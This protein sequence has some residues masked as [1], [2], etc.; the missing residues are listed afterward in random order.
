MLAASSEFFYQ[1]FIQDES[2]SVEFDVD[3]FESLVVACYSGQIQVNKTNAVRLL[4]AATFYE[5]KSVV[6]VCCDF[7]SRKMDETNCLDVYN[8]T[9]RLGLISLTNRAFEMANERFMALA[10]TNRF[11]DISLEVLT[12]LLASSNL[13]VNEEE[14]VFDIMMLWVNHLP[15]QRNEHISELLPLI[16]LSFLDSTVEYFSWKSFL[17]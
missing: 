4:E 13:V 9:K 8:L 17:K 3:V 6:D 15:D 11:L 12:E 10:K 5:M 2:Y 7:I 16:R 14:D 1:M